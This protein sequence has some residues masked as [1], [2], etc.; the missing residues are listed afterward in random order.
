MCRA[1]FPKCLFPMLVAQEMKQKQNELVK[2]MFQI[3]YVKEKY[4][5]FEKKKETP[6]NPQNNSIFD[7]LCIFTELFFLLF[8]FSFYFWQH[9][10][11]FYFFISFEIEIIV[12]LSFSIKKKTMLQ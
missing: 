8:I 4:F 5:F 11:P 6:R 3:K 7:Q 12:P 9:S 10:L 1:F 2:T